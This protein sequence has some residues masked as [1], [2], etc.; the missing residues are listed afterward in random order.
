MKKI[1]ILVL[2]I[3]IFSCSSDN[4]INNCNFLLNVSVNATINLN[5]PQFSQLINIGNPVRLEGQGNG[6][7]IIIRTGSQTLRAW[8]GADPS[9]QFSSCSI[10]S[11]V[12]VN[13]VSGCGEDI[14]Y[15]L[16]TG[17][18]IGENQQPCTLLPYRVES[19]GNN[20]FLITN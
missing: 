5:L 17:Q 2:S 19:I 10:L 3:F 4:T 11:I 7:I 1:L 13:A 14:E 9:R 8:D 6:G 18:S 20:Q 12:G 15:N 16:I